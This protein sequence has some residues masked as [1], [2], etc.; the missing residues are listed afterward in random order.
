MC[1]IFA[2]VDR[3]LYQPVKFI[4]M[5]AE[6]LNIV[7]FAPKGKDSFYEAVTDEVNSNF[8]NNHISPYANMEMWVKTVVMLLLYFVP[9]ILW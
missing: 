8:E 4:F 6:K 5:K 3:V 9:Y 7:R 2:V 1:K